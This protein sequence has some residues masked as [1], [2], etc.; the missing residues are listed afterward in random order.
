MG[1]GYE[2]HGRALY[3]DYRR[4][5]GAQITQVT[6]Y[7]KNYIVLT[8]KT[9]DFPAA[10]A[11]FVPKDQSA[12]AGILLLAYPLLLDGEPYFCPRNLAS[13]FERRFKVCDSLPPSFLG[14]SH[15]VRIDLYRVEYGKSGSARANATDVIVRIASPSN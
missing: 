12:D 10:T 5:P 11:E 9:N 3:S 2:I 14:P 15:L 4:P 7:L 6:G 8:E 1:A 13:S